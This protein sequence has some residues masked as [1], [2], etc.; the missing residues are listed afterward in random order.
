MAIKEF[1]DLDKK[2][3]SKFKEEAIV[4]PKNILNEEIKS[5]DNVFEHLLSNMGISK[6]ITAE[7]FS[8][9]IEKIKEKIKFFYSSHEAENIKFEIRSNSKNNKSTLVIDKIKVEF[10]EKSGDYFA[11]LLNIDLNEVLILEEDVKKVKSTLS[12]SDWCE[13]ELKYVIN[14]ADEDNYFQ[15]IKITP[16]FIIDIDKI[17]SENYRKKWN[18][19]SLEERIDII[20]RSVGV[21]PNLIE[22]KEK[23]KE[24]LEDYNPKELSD[25]YDNSMI[26]AK[27]H[28]IIRFIPYV[29]KNY[30]MVEIGEKGIGKT[31]F[32]TLSKKAIH[33]SIS[34]VT[35]SKLFGDGRYKYS[36]A[37]VGKKAVICLDEI[38]KGDFIK[39]IIAN[40]NTYLTNGYYEK[41]GKNNSEKI[42]ANTSFIFT[43]NNDKNIE[44]LVGRNIYNLFTP[45][46]GSI[47]DNDSIQDRIDYYLPSW[48]IEEFKSGIK[49]KRLGL[50][51]DFLFKLFNSL[52]NE[53][54]QNVLGEYYDIKYGG[55]ERD[56]LSIKKTVSGLIKILNISDKYVTQDELELY[57]KIAVEGRNRVV[58][59]NQNSTEIENEI[60]YHRKTYGGQIHQHPLENTIFYTD[61]EEELKSSEIKLINEREANQINIELYKKGSRDLRSGDE[62]IIAD[63]RKEFFD[64]DISSYNFELV[65]SEYDREIKF[66]RYSNPESSP[67]PSRGLSTIFEEI[68]E[69]LKISN[70]NYYLLDSYIKTYTILQDKLK[71]LVKKH[72]FIQK[73]LNLKMNTWEK[74]R[75]RDLEKLDFDFQLTEQIKPK[76]IYKYINRE[77]L[78]RLVCDYG[79]LDIYIEWNTE[80]LRDDYYVNYDLNRDVLDAVG[81]H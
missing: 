59:Q 9:N 57:L 56:E 63:N 81:G 35:Y 53:N 64:S 51:K 11:K 50:N 28:L 37:E 62:A 71:L 16:L 33:H 24:F 8:K 2:L 17:N 18:S 74:I 23:Y 6:N 10:D 43:G 65:I 4:C 36:T 52:R 61:D 13:L 12:N 7:N 54:Y 58:Y 3:M 70:D 32:H 69:E 34:D 14:K 49:T 42:S 47:Q 44:V 1:D 40:M 72:P 21:E 75:E 29:I 25:Y 67:Q 73:E 39:A 38:D 26:R 27:L 15:V 31:H 68:G 80:D 48:E 46:P 5:E 60:V 78:N 66:F 30:N 19:F 45:I 22:L 79:G 76:L 77:R 55:K 20:L 41:G